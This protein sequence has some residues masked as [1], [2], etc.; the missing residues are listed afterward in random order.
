MDLLA[1]TTPVESEIVTENWVAIASKI[2]T[3]TASTGDLWF[4]KRT[5]PL[6]DLE[7]VKEN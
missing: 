2:V 5:Q 4:C 1:H 3:E 6:V 7:I